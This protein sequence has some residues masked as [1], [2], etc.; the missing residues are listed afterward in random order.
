MRNVEWTQLNLLNE[1]KEYPF[2]RRT[3]LFMKKL[4]KGNWVIG[5]FENFLF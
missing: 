2:K 5:E 4:N 3:A 1:A